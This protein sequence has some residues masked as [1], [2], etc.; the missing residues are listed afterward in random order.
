MSDPAALQYKAQVHQEWTDG[1][2]A[3][4][5]WHPQFATQTRTATDIVVAL[6][7][8]RH[9][10]RVLDVGSGSGEPALTLAGAVGPTGH[11]VG[12]DLVPGMLVVADRECPAAGADESFVPAG[13]R[14]SASVPRSG[15]R[16]GDQS[17]QSHVLPG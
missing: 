4:R 9:G 2:A 7:Q 8:V 5:R 16:C 14:R 13:G 11:V 15:L 17:L 10:M 12:S 3:W 6:A 1:V